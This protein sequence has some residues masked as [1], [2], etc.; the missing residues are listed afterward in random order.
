MYIY[1]LVKRQKFEKLLFKT[2][3]FIRCVISMVGS[4]ILPIL[5]ISPCAVCT[6]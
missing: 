5:D 3:C 4:P 6:Q 1:K 2:Y